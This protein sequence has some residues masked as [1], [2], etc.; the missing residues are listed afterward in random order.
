MLK[1]TLELSIQSCIIRPMN[2]LQQRY[3]ALSVISGPFFTIF[4]IVSIMASPAVAQDDEWRVVDNPYQEDIEYQIGA[5]HT[6]GVEVEGVRWRSFKIETI[7]RGLF[8]V[9]ESVDTEVTLA[10]ENRRTKSAKILVIMLLEDE[11]GNPL[12]RIEAR[13]FK[14]AAGRLKERTENVRLS[15]EV[16]NSTRRIYVFFE[17]LQ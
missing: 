9:G 8:A 15:G 7:E 1:P 5:T 11:N 6:P 16:L 12:D 3:T 10:I 4:F 13:Q 2:P 14:V 17:I